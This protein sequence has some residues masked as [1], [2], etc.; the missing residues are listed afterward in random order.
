MNAQL[1]GSGGDGSNGSPGRYPQA[2]VGIRV[3]PVR[4][5]VINA[6][7]EGHECRCRKPKDDLKV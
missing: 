5:R 4:L 1:E 6:V 3:E 2:S 7:D